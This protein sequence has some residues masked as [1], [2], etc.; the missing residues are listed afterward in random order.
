VPLDAAAV[1]GAAERLREFLARL[2]HAEAWVWTEES[3]DVQQVTVVFHVD[4]GR[5]YQVREVRFEGASFRTEAELWSALRARLAAEPGPDVPQPRAD[6]DA[7]AVASGL[8][9]RDPAP[10]L[11]LDLAEVYEPRAWAKALEELAGEHRDEGF[12]DAAAEVGRVS[13]DAKAGLAEIRVRVREGVRTFVRSLAF[14]GN[15]RIPSSQ[16]APQVRV[17][18]GAPL[19]LRRVEEARQAIATAYLRKGFVYA[20]V[21][22][23]PE[24]EPDRRAAAVRF[25]IEEG[26]EVRIS[27][28]VVEGNKRTRT[29]LIERTVGIRPGQ[30]YDPK[31]IAAAQ[32]EL[33]RLGIF[34]TVALQ[35]SDPDVPQASKELVVSVDERPYQSLTASAGISFAEGPRVG[36]EYSRPNLGGGAVEFLTRLRANYPLEIFRPDLVVIPAAERLE[37]LGELGVRLPRFL[38]VRYVNVRVDL[39]GQ[40]KIQSSYELLRGALIAGLDLARLGPLGASLTGTLEVNEVTSRT[41]YTSVFDLDSPEKARLLFPVGLTTLVSVQPRVSLDFRDNV[42]RPTLGF[43]AE[44]SMDYSRSIGVPGERVL[45]V[46]PGS[47]TYINLIRLEGLLSGYLPLG[48]SV[49]ALSVRMGRVFQLDP[50]N[51]DSTV[52][53]PKRFYLGGATSMRGY[54][55]NEMPPEDQRPLLVDQTARCASVLSGI[56]CSTQQQQL[57]QQGIILPSEG[58]QVFALMRAELRVPLTQA[59]EAGFF[60]EWG[61]LWYDPNLVD[62]S[63]VRTNVGLGF[64]ILTPV[65]PAAFDVGFNLSPD[66]RINEPWFAPHFAVGFF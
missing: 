3:G 23:S 45:G 20:R 54:G 5:R 48:R 58:A 10:R 12:L 26:P 17:E 6:L 36:V 30:V 29:G 8:A 11:V 22:A 31:E 33:L 63:K 37:W 2:G 7:M 62:L 43:F 57:V 14:E 13:L 25:R 53:A 28:V 51:P 1:E 60:A 16:L 64:R 24:F 34:R 42:A 32:G 9:P 27:A 4:A 39:V 35:L 44:V 66:Y 47:E 40:H 52:I 65:G 15:A 18:A 55:V 59:T 38:D 61:N 41:A 50:T 19:S 21:E 56:G 46:L 49:L